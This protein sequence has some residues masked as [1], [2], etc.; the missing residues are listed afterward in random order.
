MNTPV[1]NHP[2]MEDVARVAG[3]SRALVSLVFRDSPK[4]SAARRDR[5]LEAAEHLGYR[6]NAMARHLASRTTRTLGVLLNDLHNPFFAD[7]YDGVETAASS[8]GYRLL[9]TAGRHR[10][11]SEHNAIDTMLQHRV[12]AMILI[13]PRIPAA[14][15]A[16]FSRQAPLVVLGRTV[17]GS[18]IDSIMADEAQGALAAVEHLATLGHRSIVHIDGGRGAGAAARRAGFE[19]AISQLGLGIP[20][21]VPGDFTEMSGV[22]ATAGLLQRPTMPTAIFAANDI[23][24]LGVIDTLAGAGLRVPDDVSVLGYDN[25]A[26]ARMRHISLTTVDQPRI[27]MGEMAVHLLDQRVNARRSTSVTH[28]MRPTLMTRRSTAPP[29]EA[30]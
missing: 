29:R 20:D 10:D 2:T 5:V 7:I 17:E 23:V 13:S 16:S 15:I 30:S 9:L 18:A 14:D 4:V 24:A 25:T 27:E 6:P 8:L 3:V 26:L 12:D 11:G 1:P 21:V 28:L 22:T 19:R